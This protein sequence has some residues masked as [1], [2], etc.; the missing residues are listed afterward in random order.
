[1]KKENT[2][3]K[4]LTEAVK[5]FAAKGFEAVTVEMIA[6]AVGIKAPSLYKHYQSK[7]EIFNRILNKMEQL[8]AAGA[9]DCSLPAESKEKTPEAYKGISVNMLVSYCE[10]QFRYW[11]ENEFASAFRRM[12]TIEQYQNEKMNALYHQYL[13]HGPLKYVTDLLQS[14]EK[15]LALYGPMHLLY[16][17]YDQA[18][19]KTAITSMLADHLKNWLA[20]ETNEKNQNKQ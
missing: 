19:E 17:I 10:K 16:G 9:A 15:A 8:D 11:T 1:M 14:T 12:L 13:G 5:L 3:E 20:N 18:T 6:A 7:Q 4:I 2:K